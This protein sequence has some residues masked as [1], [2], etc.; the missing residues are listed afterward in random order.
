M[1]TIKTL[2]IATA[3]ALALV[4][5]AGASAASA[6]VFNSPG[7]GAEATSWSGS[8]S[9]TTSHRLELGYDVFSCS[10]SNFSGQMTGEESK[11]ITVTPTLGCKWNTFPVAWE[12]NGCK[13]RFRAGALAGMTGT[14]SIV[15]CEKP[16]TFTHSGCQITVNNQSG[17]GGSVEYKNVETPTPSTVTM[18]ANLTGII[19]TSQGGGCNGGLGTDGAFHGVWTV[20]GYRG[21]TQQP[22]RLKATTPV[23][24]AAEEAPATIAGANTSAGTTYY[25]G[26]VG[27]NLV[28]NNYSLSGT[29]ASAT[30]GSLTLTPTYKGCTVGGEAISDGS[31][32]AGGCSFVFYA[33]GSL[34]IA[35]ATCASNP[36]TFAHAGCVITIGP[37]GGLL[38]FSYTNEGSGKLRSVSIAGQATN[39]DYYKLT[40]TAGAGCTTPGTY[41]N[42]K[43]NSVA[44]LTATNSKGLAQGLWLE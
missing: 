31:V 26:T 43:I 20:K 23:N 30:T 40:Y 11:E 6:A 13:F 2:G 16:M 1:R 25:K 22:I 44:K 21:V 37:Q 10:E 12:M 39:P 33:G 35:G 4:A 14:M 42:A 8:R 5:V 27:G 18:N 36:I 38:G 24:F 28:C 17:L 15:G 29:S 34:A 32:S 41:S 3:V 19:Y 7:A 9:G